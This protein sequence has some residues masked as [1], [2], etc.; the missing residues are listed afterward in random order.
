MGA[1]LSGQH[2]FAQRIRHRDDEGTGADTSISSGR[3]AGC[4]TPRLG[5]FEL[6]A[7]LGVDVGLVRG[8]GF[9]LENPGTVRPLWVAA[10]PGLRAHWRVRDRFGLGVAMDVPVSLRRPTLMIDD[11]DTALV[12]AGSAGVW[13]GL[14]ID[15]TFFDESA[16]RRG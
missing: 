9:G 12:Q 13:L 3:A 8:E 4:W 2:L 1:E 7:C 10:T 14:S 16:G 11:F 15:F 5:R 6:G